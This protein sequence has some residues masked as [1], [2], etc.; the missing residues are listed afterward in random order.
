IGVAQEDAPTT[1]FQMDGDAAASYP[2]GATG[3][4]WSQVYSDFKKTTTNASATGAINFFN[5]SI[6]TA[7][8]GVSPTPTED[9]FTGGNS[10]DTNDMS[11]WVYNSGSPQN[12]ADLENAFGAA[13]IDPNNGHTYLYVGT[14]RYDNGG[15]IAL[16]VWFLQTPVGTSGGKF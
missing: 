8:T 15:S 10:K 13:Y 12:K 1:I 5:D 9:T 6:G 14:T 7:V 3:H 2:A 11:M 16:G 4:D